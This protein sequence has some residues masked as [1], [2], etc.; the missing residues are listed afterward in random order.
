MRT[1][2][3]RTR[4]EHEAWVKDNADYFTVVFARG[5]IKLEAPTFEEA[6]ALA[7]E[8]MRGLERDDTQAARIYATKGQDGV[9]VAT[10][11][12]IRGLKMVEG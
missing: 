12:P 5:S 8:R 2:R 1:Y 4:L 3:G 9:V 7:V 10:Y 11:H 6:K